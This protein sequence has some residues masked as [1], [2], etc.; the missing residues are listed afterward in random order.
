MD[1]DKIY[2]AAQEKAYKKITAKYNKKISIIENNTSLTEEEKQLCYQKLAT[3]LEKAS[4]RS[5]KLGEIKENILHTVGAISDSQLAT[6]AIGCL[7]AAS[8][9]VGG[10]GLLTSDTLTAAQNTVNTLSGIA[11]GLGAITTLYSA[12][13]IQGSDGSSIIDKMATQKMYENIFNREAFAEVGNKLNDLTGEQNLST[14]FSIN[15][16][17]STDLGIDQSP[18]VDTEMT[19]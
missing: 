10:L 3:K 9:L 1:T 8:M 4:A 11:L 6:L 2:K 12:S 17:T 15:Q 14:D 18:S 16:P 13:N 19:R 5:E 7:G